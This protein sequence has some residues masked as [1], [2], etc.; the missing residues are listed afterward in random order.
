MKTGMSAEDKPWGGL[1]SVFLTEADELEA[2][3]NFGWFG[4]VC[5]HFKLK[6]KY[7]CSKIYLID[8]LIG[9]N[10][11]IFFRHESEWED[12]FCLDTQERHAHAD[13]RKEE[14]KSEL[15]RFAGEVNESFR[16]WVSLTNSQI[17]IDCINS[18]TLHYCDYECCFDEPILPVPSSVVY[19]INELLFVF[20]SECN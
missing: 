10:P 5:V 20:A 11:M 17:A 8:S 9:K 1:D 14:C 7:L 3:E 13:A 6:R 4:T 16:K 18:F 2:I 19:T 12:W 15:T